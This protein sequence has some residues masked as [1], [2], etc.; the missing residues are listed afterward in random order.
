MRFSASFVLG[1]ME[2]HYGGSIIQFH[3]ESVAQG[4]GGESIAFRFNGCIELS[5][6]QQRVLSEYG[7]MPQ[8]ISVNYY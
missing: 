2:I 3:P 4:E 1:L 8:N 5:T 7:H 6:Q